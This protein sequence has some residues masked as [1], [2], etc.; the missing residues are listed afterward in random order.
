MTHRR[1]RILLVPVVLAGLVSAAAPAVPLQPGSEYRAALTPGITDAVG[2]PLA[3][4]FWR[5]TTKP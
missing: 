3:W 4:T 5:F 1:L 2:N